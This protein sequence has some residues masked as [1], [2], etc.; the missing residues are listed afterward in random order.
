M[1]YQLLIPGDNAATIE[2]STEHLLET[3]K[4]AVSAHGSFFI[5][6]SGGSTPKAIYEKLTRPPYSDQ[7]DWSKV[8]LF[9][10]DERSAL[11]TDPESNYKMAMEAGFKKMPI[12]PKQIHRMCA[13]SEIEKNAALYEKTIRALGRPFDLIM[14]G[15]G[16]DGHTA[17]LFPGTKALTIQDRL[18][19]ANFVPQ[20]NTWR[21]TLTFPCINQAKNIVVY[22]LGSSKKEMVYKILNDEEIQYP[23][24]HVGSPLHPALW[25]L[26]TAAAEKLLI[27]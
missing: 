22:V 8:W 25:I 26:D 5:A 2:A 23:I 13:E 12:P 4:Q 21:M 14:L 10:S 11:P 17:S 6:L 16:E 27:R 15:M 20:K 18:V 1:Y 7:I 19:A 3:Y 24:Q 9:W